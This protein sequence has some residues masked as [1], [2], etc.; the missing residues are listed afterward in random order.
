MK[1]KFSLFVTN[2]RF[3]ITEGVSSVL[4]VKGWMR[5]APQII[6][7]KPHLTLAGLFGLALTPALAQLQPT[8]G[9]DGTAI[10]GKLNDGAEVAA[11][12]AEKRAFAIRKTDQKMMRNGAML[13]MHRI[14]PPPPKVADPQKEDE[15]Q[16]QWS[17]EEIQQMLEGFR[18]DIYISIGATVIDHEITY[19]S[20]SHG[21]ERY[22]AYSNI[23]F[24]HMSGFGGFK[25][26]GQPYS[27][28]MGISN[29][30]S[31][32]LEEDE[33]NA[34]PKLPDSPP[35]FEVV[36]GDPDNEEALSNIVAL[37]QLYAAEG[38]RLEAAYQKREQARE[39]R[40]AYL[41]AYPPQPEDMEVYFWANHRSQTM[42]RP[43]PSREDLTTDRERQM[44]AALEARRNQA[45]EGGAR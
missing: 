1:N 29:V 18:P 24:N 19:L 26:D 39:D 32:W 6:D 10:I 8:L 36:A 30:K 7:M 23:D 21:E 17:E 28:F 27:F 40:A 14:D 13:K 44:R 20:W 42:K 15:A 38:K 22:A 9:G 31:E 37:H 35:Q 33:M 2:W 3:W 4:P 43:L 34:L 12:P 16:R 41:E 25:V 11:A 45:K 5:E